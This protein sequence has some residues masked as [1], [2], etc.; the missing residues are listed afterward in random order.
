MNVLEKWAPK[1]GCGSLSLIWFHSWGQSKSTTISMKEQS[2]NW[3]YKIHSHPSRCRTLSHFS[4]SQ[5]PMILCFHHQPCNKASL[6]PFLITLWKHSMHHLIKIKP[7]LLWG[8]T[9]R[10]RREEGKE[11]MPTSTSFALFFLLIPRYNNYSTFHF[12]LQSTYYINLHSC[13]YLH[14]H[15]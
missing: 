1:A 10:L 8:I 13:S 6:V 4:C 12:M 7:L 15:S 11:S 14:H 2:Q 9:K 5:T 3:N